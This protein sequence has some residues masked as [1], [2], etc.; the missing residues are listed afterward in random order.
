MRALKTKTIL[1]L[2][3]GTLI[4]SA[5]L[6]SAYYPAALPVL[7]SDG[8]PL[9]GLDGTPIVH[10]DMTKYYLVNSPSLILAASSVSLFIWWLIRVARVLYAR[11]RNGWK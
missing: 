6:I 8:T 9:V 1:F 10:R 3:I 4:L 2:A 5:V 7:G 11:F